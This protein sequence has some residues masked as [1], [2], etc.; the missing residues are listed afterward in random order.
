MKKKVI[1][2]Y[3]KIRQQLWFRP[4]LFCLFS[5]FGALL[6]HQIDGFGISKHVPSIDTDSIK[7]LLDTISSSMLVIS[8]FAVTSMLSAFSS[9][10]STA[11]PRSFKIVVTDDVSQ[12]ALSVFIGAFIF[13]IVATIALDNGYYQKAGRFL[14]FLLTLIL[15]TVVILTFLRWVD[16][17]SRLGR[18]EHTIQQI[19]TVASKALATY[20]KYP[21]LKANPIKKK[22][23]K[24]NAI[25]GNTI[26][27]IQHINIE[28]L[29]ELAEEKKIKI[30]LNCLPGKFINK[31][32]VVAYVSET[33]IE[34]KEIQQSINSAIHVGHNR[35]YEDD[36]RLGFTSLTEIASR[37]LSP[38][39]NDP[40]TA[41]QIIGCHE[42]LFFLW[43]QKA[44]EEE[45]EHEITYN[46][47]EV[48]QIAI[49]D[50]FDDA[51][52]PIAR[53]GANNIEVMLRLQKTFKSIATIDND[54][55]KKNALKN[56]EDAYNRA[57]KAIEFNNDL[58]LLRKKC[59]F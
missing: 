25:C 24:A 5:V 33:D 17:I 35:L 29:Q 52:R 1:I 30:Q 46:R 53:D 55:F 16:K 57:E 42:R 20:I 31:N 3:N 4:L 51:F 18:L 36:P 14:L 13:S 39:I 58:I 47:V 40:G 28:V 43:Q 22:F 41:I 37:A 11:T 48:P 45:Q 8:I 49:A 9:A 54:K 56:S 50:F 38:G 23:N 15:F 21:N 27:Y 12:N 32:F 2:Y 59:L 34:I 6:A 26:G 10:S 19:E 44:Q 7:G